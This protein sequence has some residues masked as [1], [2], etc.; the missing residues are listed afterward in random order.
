MSTRLV[1]TYRNDGQKQ[2]LSG[3]AQYIMLLDPTRTAMAAMK[4]MLMHPVEL[5]KLPEVGTLVEL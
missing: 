2:N 3:D 1:R 4:T 5:C